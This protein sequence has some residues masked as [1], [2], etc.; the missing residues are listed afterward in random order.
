MAHVSTEKLI[1]FT[2]CEE[3]QGT[4]I[5]RVTEP[6]RNATVTRESTEEPR[7]GLRRKPSRLNLFIP[8]R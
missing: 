6:Y 3:R 1:P 4:F 8:P 5:R 2:H 7:T